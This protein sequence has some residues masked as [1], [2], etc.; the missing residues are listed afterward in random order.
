MS[1]YVDDSG[2]TLRWVVQ[3]DGAY[4]DELDV[5]T[6]D[7]PEREGV[8]VMYL[9]AGDRSIELHR[10]STSRDPCGPAMVVRHLRELLPQ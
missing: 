3:V 1:P 9:V 10:W 7:H 2:E 5:R 6:E 8:V 4:V